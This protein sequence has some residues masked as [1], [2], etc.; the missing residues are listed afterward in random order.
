MGTGVLKA[1]LRRWII[2]RAGVPACEQCEDPNSTEAW[3]AQKS[4]RSEPF[5]TLGLGCGIEVSHKAWCMRLEWS[6]VLF[7]WV[8]GWLVLGPAVGIEG[9]ASICTIST[10]CRVLKSRASMHCAR[11]T[12]LASFMKADQFISRGE[13]PFFKLQ[14]LLLL[15]LLNGK[16]LMFYTKLI[17]LKAG[18][19]AYIRGTSAKDGFSFV[20]NGHQDWGDFCILK[21][22]RILQMHHA[23]LHIISQYGYGNLE[24]TL[25]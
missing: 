6:C 18:L 25:I 2:A 7:V 13:R 19:R 14:C 11:I 4:Q 23:I 22:L 21:K 9:S 10:P 5:L 16:L 1:A 8:F 24:N 3:D 15:L 17:F 20:P 12:S